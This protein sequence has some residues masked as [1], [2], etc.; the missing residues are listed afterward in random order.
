MS[1]LVTYAEWIPGE[2]WYG[3]DLDGTL[4]IYTTYQNGKI[5]SPIPLMVSRVRQWLKQGKR[6]KI[7]AARIAGGDMDEAAKIQRWCK[8]Y[9]GQ[10]LEITNAKDPD[11]VDLWDDRAVQLIPNTGVRIDSLVKQT[12]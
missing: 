9:I 7:M 5:G 3:V 12:P 2:P 4:A 11:M 6:V 8:R 1:G 10:V